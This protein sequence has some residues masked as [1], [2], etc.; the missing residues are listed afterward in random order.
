MVRYPEDL[1][2]TM[3]GNLAEGC[4]LGGETRNKSESYNKVLV[5]FMILFKDLHSEYLCHSQS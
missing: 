1:D 5:L 3:Y 4:L 2:L